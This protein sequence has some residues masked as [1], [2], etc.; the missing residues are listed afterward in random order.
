MQRLFR[1]GRGADFARL[2]A[3][4]QRWSHP[5]VSVTVSPNALSHNRY[6]FVI[7]RRQGNAVTRNRVRRLLREAV[8]HSHSQLRAGFDLAFVA[9][10]GISHQPYS[11]IK[12]ALESLFRRAGLWMDAER[13]GDAEEA[14]R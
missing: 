14:T 9:R 8:R 3:Q 4:G 11:E 12:E 1:L 5:L 7:S 10:N 2:R 13:A 6:G